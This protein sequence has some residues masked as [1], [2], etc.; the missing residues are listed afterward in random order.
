MSTVHVWLVGHRWGVGSP[1][2]QMGGVTGGRIGAISSRRSVTGLRMSV[3]VWPM[4]GRQPPICV[5][6]VQTSAT[7][8]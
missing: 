5:R 8:C 7:R 1:L 3:S 6:S 2:R 4:S